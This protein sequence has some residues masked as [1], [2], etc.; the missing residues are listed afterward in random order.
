MIDNSDVSRLLDILGNRNR[1]RIIDL[2][3]QKPC[4]VTEIS[5]KLMISPKA[6]IEHL[7][8]MEDEEILSSFHDDRRR[9][10][11]Y[12]VREIKVDVRFEGNKL[13]SLPPSGESKEATKY[14]AALFMLT[15][16]LRTRE[17]LIAHLEEIERDIE[18]KMNDVVKYS[19]EIL[20]NE[21]EMDMVLALAHCTLTLQDLEEYT[22]LGAEP[23]EAMLEDLIGKGIVEQNGNEYMLSVSYAE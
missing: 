10:Y 8:L 14:L 20:S 11:Y 6:V 15:R 18:V 19:R 21:T 13:S 16:M 23:V 9:K 5:D 1:R 12:L 3:R 22:G 7:Q 4:F 2:L 17:T